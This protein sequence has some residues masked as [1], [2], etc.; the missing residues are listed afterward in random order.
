MIPQTSPS[1]RICHLRELQSTE[2][3][4]Q[5]ENPNKTVSNESFTSKCRMIL[6]IEMTKMSKCT[7]RKAN[8]NFSHKGTTLKTI[9]G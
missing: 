5:I 3:P 8:I 7:N 4:K 1:H 2:G 9:P 6:F